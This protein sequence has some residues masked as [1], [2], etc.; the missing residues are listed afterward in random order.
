M[1]V[2]ETHIMDAERPMVLCCCYILITEDGRASYCGITNNFERRLV[3]HRKGCH[4]GGARYTS[5]RRER[6]WI[7][8][9]V[10]HGFS[11]RSQCLSF[12]WRVKRVRSCCES[13]IMRRCEQLMRTLNNRKWWLQHPP[14]PSRMRIEWLHRSDPPPLLTDH[15]LVGDPFP[16]TIDVAT[17]DSGGTKQIDQL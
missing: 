4:A 3:Q 10:V 2:R 14:C 13:C 9:C 15:H 17:R 5:A 7:P 11:N 8:L 1:G 16:L 6:R 12:E